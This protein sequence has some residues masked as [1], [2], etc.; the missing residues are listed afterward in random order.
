MSGITRQ[1]KADDFSDL[2]RDCNP[3]RYRIS[4]KPESRLAAIVRDMTTK[5]QTLPITSASLAAGA[6]TLADARQLFRIYNH[7]RS[8]LALCLLA[9]ILLPNLGRLTVELDTQLYFSGCGLL[10]LTSLPLTTG[11]WRRAETSPTA[12]FGLLLVDVFVNA[13][14][15]TATG[16]IVSGFSVFYV[17]TAAASAVLL[18]QRSLS[19]LIAAITVIAVLGESWL[20]YESTGSA[21]G[22]LPAGMFGTLI[23]L[24][25]LA[26]Q[27]LSGRLFKAESTALEAQRQREALKALNEEIILHMSTGVLR[28]DN[29]GLLHPI[30]QQAHQWLA[31]DGQFPPSLEQLYPPLK[32]QFNDW[33][34]GLRV[35]RVPFKPNPDAPELVASF[36]DTDSSLGLG[37]L[38]FLEDHSP[39]KLRA[40][41]LKLQS[42]GK[43]AGS[44]AHEIRNPLAAI[45][46]ASQLLSEREQ[47]ESQERQLT[48]IVVKNCERVSGIIDNVL[49]VSR[50]QPPE[51]QQLE[52]KTWLETFVAEYLALRQDSPNIDLL[53]DRQ[54]QI[55]FDP[56]HLRRVLT[57]L[58][59]NALR[60]SQSQTQ[61]LTAR[62]RF[63]ANAALAKCHLDIEDDGVGVSEEN[64]PHLFEPFFTTAQGGSGLGLYL[65]Q[66]LCQLNGAELTYLNRDNEQPSTFRLAITA[67]EDYA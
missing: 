55:D 40:Q 63:T 48:D 25:T 42:L 1:L 54:I 49:S 52:L 32:Q 7:Y 41:T 56:Q 13:L 15:V 34:Q 59:D 20:Q 31:L 36:A 57:N 38:I 28:V 21:N 16:G 53:M 26:V 8:G 46:H 65:C 5:Q 66:D 4:D 58:L 50:R 44:I 39:V 17:I 24:V 9:L 51:V 67:L 2:G 11:I 43:L 45:S 47:W 62:I 27:I 3:Q 19:L 35:S 22:L 12:A 23:F 37:A 61:A 64:L 33:K 29:Q 14:V 6:G 60:H 10:L 30:N 18:K